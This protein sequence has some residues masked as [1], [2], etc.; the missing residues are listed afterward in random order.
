M[1]PLTEKVKNT[2]IDEHKHFV[3]LIDNKK[4]MAIAK[5]ALQ[6]DKVTDL[7]NVV[8]EYCTSQEEAIGMLMVAT[9]MVRGGDAIMLA[10]MLHDAE[11]LEKTN[12]PLGKIPEGTEDEFIEN[13]NE[14]VLAKGTIRDILNHAI[15]NEFSIEEYCFIF[16]NAL[17]KVYS[18]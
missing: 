5:L 11:E 12:P 6:K 2:P 8:L 16:F 10:I 15:A 13:V 7:I 3:D 18:C 14:K 1:T 9:R 4:G 17:R